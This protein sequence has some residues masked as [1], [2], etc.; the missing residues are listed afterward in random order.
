VERT[1]RKPRVAGIM[2]VYTPNS[3]ADVFFSR[4]L[5]GYHLEG[6]W[7]A[8][9]L[10]LVSAYVAQVPPTD[11]SAEA[12]AEYGFKIYPTIAEA[13]R[14]GGSRL[15]VDAVAHI[16]E[17]GDYPL[18]SRGQKMY[19]RYEF[20]KEVTRVMRED[21]R[22]VPLYVDK[23]FSYEWPRA[24]E[25]YITA[26]E[27]KIP[28]MAGST[29]S[30]TK[31]VPPLQ[32]APGTELQESMVVGFGETDG[33]GFHALE[34]MQAIV[35][36][37]RGGETGVASVRAFQGPDVWGLAE[38]GLWSRD[39]FDAALLRTPSRVQ[40]RPEDLV[41]QPVL[42]VVN[43]KDGLKGQILIC[44][45]LLRSWV[46]AARPKGGG[47]ILSTDCR[48]SF[49]LHTH[50]GYMVRN[51][52]NLVLTGRL[53]NPVERTLL[54]TGIL[55]F[56]FESLSQGGVEVPTPQLGISYRA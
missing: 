32:L 53:P 13:L 2:N 40:G 31:R 6:S 39:L 5:D 29:V 10:E 33:Y 26:R 1:A 14:C 51:F 22:V 20:F 17:H 30:L 15:A 46:F 3:H 28:L 37:R 38:K 47:G 7:H 9:R 24:L 45:G 8:A 18:N 56:A 49:P 44:N 41:K 52:E 19:P 55:A 54:T 25:M 11:S 36:K 35:E 50:W 34:A 4:V 21:K 12:S 27:M 42:F 48:I 16:G 23:H 43:Y